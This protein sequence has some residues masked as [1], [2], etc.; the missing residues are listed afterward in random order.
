VLPAAGMKDLQRVL[1]PVAGEASGGG[2]GCGSSGGSSCGGG[3]GCGG[4][5]GH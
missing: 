3:S 2:S 5:G 4:C 1:L